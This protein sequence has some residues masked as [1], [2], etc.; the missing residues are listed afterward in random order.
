MSTFVQATVGVDLVVTF[1]L[2]AQGDPGAI[3]FETIV[4]PGSTTSGHQPTQT[5]IGTE[6]QSGNGLTHKAILENAVSGRLT[7]SYKQ[8]GNAVQ[9]NDN[10]TIKTSVSKDFTGTI[11]SIDTEIL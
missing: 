2:S 9:I 7:I 4:S 1:D 3:T 6:V 10:G 8:N 11:C 5:V